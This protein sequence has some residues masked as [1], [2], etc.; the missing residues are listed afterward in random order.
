MT[1]KKNT[2][3]SILKILA[4][5]K[6][7][8]LEELKNSESFENPTEKYALSRSIK[9]MID[10]GFAET[11][12]SDQKDY[13]RLTPAGRRK[14]VSSELS[15]GTMPVPAVWDNKWRIVIL[16]LPENRK[17]ER[18]ALRYLLKKAGFA[19]VK[20]TVWVSPYP[21]EHMFMNIKKDLGLK[22]ELIIVITDSI[23]SEMEREL[24]K[25]FGK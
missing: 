14:L 6:A 7:V 9:N 21:F 25:I 1:N 18:E 24:H 5:K 15:S 23:D 4:R 19:C 11:L 17:N 10:S 22:T 8:S 16:D 13:V 20:N 2:Q 12:S 3:N